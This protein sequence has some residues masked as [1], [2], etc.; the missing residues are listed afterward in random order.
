[1]TTITESTVQPLAVYRNGAWDPPSSEWPAGPDVHYVTSI[2]DGELITEIHE[3]ELNLAIEP[4]ADLD[5]QTRCPRCG[6]TS[7]GTAPCLD[8]LC[9]EQAAIYR[10]NPQLSEDRVEN[11]RQHE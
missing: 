6:R 9:I 1:M 10:D 2:R 8:C 7:W 5:I 11:C 4:R 3:P